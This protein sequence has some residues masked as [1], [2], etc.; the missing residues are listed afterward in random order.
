M[1][2]KLQ[3]FLSEIE[4]KQ[5]REDAKSL[6]KIIEEESGFKPSLKGKIIGYG[7]YEFKYQSGKVGHRIVTG[8]SPRKQNIAIYII[9]GFSKYKKELDKLGKH[10]ISSKCCLYV[11]KLSDIDEMIFRKIIKQSVLEMSKR[12]EVKNA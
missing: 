10:K 4:N 12:H 5:K 11:N 8:F 6:I 7:L 9:N 3:E 2:K 1:I